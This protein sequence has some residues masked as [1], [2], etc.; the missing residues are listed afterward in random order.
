MRNAFENVPKC[1]GV[2]A[3]GAEWQN[4]PTASILRRWTCVILSEAKDLDIERVFRSR[5]SSLRSE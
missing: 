4:E 3:R 1:S 2:F 5:D